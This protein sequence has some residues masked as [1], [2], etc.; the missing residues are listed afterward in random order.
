MAEM[1][2]DWGRPLAI[3]V[4]GAAAA[5]IGGSSL[6]GWII[7]HPPPFATLPGSTPVAASAALGCL[8][9]GIAVMASVSE[10]RS[11]RVLRY[12]A[13]ILLVLLGTLAVAQVA[14]GVDARIDFP[15]MHS[16]VDWQGAP[17]GRVAP[18]TA[19]ALLLTGLLLAFHDRVSNRAGA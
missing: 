12:S 15:A 8:M 1:K 13:S 14:T 3:V 2:R 11:A 10:A 9:A 7:G 16:I 5:A 6:L 19:I 17:P 18:T 4:P